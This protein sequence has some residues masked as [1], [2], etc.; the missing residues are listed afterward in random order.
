MSTVAQLQQ[1]TRAH[2]Q[3]VLESLTP[4]PPPL[5]IDEGGVLR[6]GSTRVRL[7][8]V[9][10]AF[11]TGSTAEEI[12]TD[13]STLNLPDIYL[14][15]AYY[16]RHREVVDAYLAEGEKLGAAVQQENETRWPKE[17]LKERL[18]ARRT[19]REQGQCSDT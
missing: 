19:A 15:I 6:V 11:N 12:L 4:E 14:V 17:G 8:T 7:D 5:R 2:A 10:Y 3:K 16:L 18:L 9:I 13:Y 1:T